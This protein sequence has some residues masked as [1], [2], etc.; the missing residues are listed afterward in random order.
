[1]KK[2]LI[3]PSPM[4]QGDLM[5]AGKISDWLGEDFDLTFLAYAQNEHS[6]FW[7]QIRGR[8][9]TL[10]ASFYPYG[11]QNY[12]AK[13]ARLATA[14]AAVQP[15]ATVV[16]NDTVFVLAAVQTGAPTVVFTHLH[17]RDLFQAGRVAFQRLMARRGFGNMDDSLA[18]LHSNLADHKFSF[19]QWFNETAGIPDAAIP[20]AAT[21]PALKSRMLAPLKAIARRVLWSGLQNRFRNLQMINRYP[22]YAAST[23][24]AY[25]LCDQ[26]IAHSVFELPA[27]ELDQLNRDRAKVDRV[28]VLACNS[29]VPDVPLDISSRIPA[30]RREIAGDF[31]KKADLGKLVLVTLG[32]F[33]HSASDGLKRFL[34]VLAAAMCQSAAGRCRWIFAGKVIDTQRTLFES[35]LLKTPAGRAGEIGFAGMT[36]HPQHL[37]LVAASD[38]V[39]TQ[40]GYSTI[41]EI[42]AARKPLLLVYGI[43][44]YYEQYGNYL[45]A[46]AAGLCLNDA[47][48]PQMQTGACAL[49]GSPAVVREKELV[50]FLDRVLNRE[51]HEPNPFASL[52]ASQEKSFHRNPADAL[53]S[54]KAALAAVLPSTALVTAPQEPEGS[55][56]ST[57]VS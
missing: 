51:L 28:P 5:I 48:T 50:S 53:P 35:F 9:V 36:S 32:G 24:L 33:A 13:A 26:L 19:L 3:L 38:L 30:L 39:I 54:L 15:D 14:L 42:A 10:D 8:Q 4:G 45:A 43:D 6:A 18:C 44:S 12:G 34:K 21:R 27:A 25:L 55:V 41:C 1:M 47:G 46:N 17:N 40:P 22:C 37:N 49:F 57:P 52:K 31:F 16:L 29:P 2:L 11:D 23:Y 20:A 56:S 7:N